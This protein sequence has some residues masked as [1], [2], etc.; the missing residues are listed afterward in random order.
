MNG[1]VHQYNYQLV[2]LSFVLAMVGSF[3]ALTIVTYLR[4]EHT[5]RTQLIMEIAGAFV[6]GGT[7]WSMHF[8]GMLAMQMRMVV[9]Y[10]LVTTLVSL[11]AAI[12]ASFLAFHTIAQRIISR[13]RH[14]FSALVMGAGIC[15]MHYIGM[16]AMQID[17]EV[18]HNP[19]TY[20]LSALI[21]VGASWA[22][23]WMA[24]R[25]LAGGL[26]HPKLWR[27]LAAGIMAFAICGMHYVGMMAAQVFPFA[28]C[29]F[30]ES[31]PPYT[32]IFAILVLQ[33]MT[34]ATALAVALAMREKIDVTQGE[35]FTLQRRLLL[36]GLF[37]AVILSI[38]IVLA[39]HY[40]AAEIKRLLP[41]SDG[42]RLAIQVHYSVV[43]TCFFLAYKFLVKIF[44]LRSMRH[45]YSELEQ[46][47]KTLAL[48]I[49]QKEKAEHELQRW[50]IEVETA[51]AAAM[52]AKE[53][54]ENANSAKSEFLANMS[55]EI[56]TPMN[57][58]LGMTQLLLTTPLNP[59]QRGWAEIVLRSGEHLL[60]II[61]DVLDFSKIEAGKMVLEPINFDLHETIQEI[62]NVVM[63]RTQAKGLELL[64]EF[65]PNVPRFLVGD[66][67]RL[68]QVVLNLVGNAIKFTETGHVLIRVAALPDVNQTVRLFLEIED[69]GCGIPADK[70]DYI[71][72]KFTQAEE[73]TTRK[74]GGTGLGLAIS[75]ELVEMMQGKIGVRS[76]VGKGTTF[77][78]DIVL[79]EGQAVGRVAAVAD[80]NLEFTRVLLVNDYLPG[81]QIAHDI[82]Q[83]EGVRCNIAPSAEAM[84]EALNE[85]EAGGDPYRFVILDDHL[86]R[87]RLLH[88]AAKI[89]GRQKAFPRTV[90]LLAPT[91]SSAQA[92]DTQDCLDG[93]LHKPCFAEYLLGML[94]LLQ[95]DSGAHISHQT[96]HKMLRGERVS[97]NEE[98]VQFPGKRALVV[99]DLKVN[100]LLMAKLLTDLGCTVDK[101][102]NGKEA[103]SLMQRLR[104][105]I[106]FM[107]C[108]MPEM[109][110]FEATRAIRNME[111]GKSYQTVIVALT[112]D[113]LTGDREKCLAAGMDDYINK[114]FKLEDIVNTI[115]KWH[116]APPAAV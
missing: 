32:L 101:A 30:G 86:G 116:K 21:A 69:T 112:A 11:F 85:A 110:G 5:R 55:H 23:L 16:A 14:L 15:C 76:G 4:G 93:V 79:P 94:R 54:A 81:A 26:S 77:H 39:S 115:K 89:K 72:E 42:E 43:L 63:L 80:G 84:L 45:W 8:I 60:D 73:S 96:V 52:D 51:R 3:V 47:R 13:K 78:F 106:V 113:A 98:K 1:V 59:E 53:A 36:G 38:W 102:A 104:Y 99:D 22:A 48:R 57:G 49:K 18:R 82:L 92:P 50:I 46:T 100:Q 12:A 9:T 90:A 19:I 114:P 111:A 27:L 62:C 34:G 103:V 75:R 67:G 88:Y 65:M 10:D 83:Q 41:N 28:D 70:L 105:E 58:V 56:R 44:V 37:Y 24:L 108:Q 71:F 91:A 6:L 64:V 40:F 17:A 95:K 2:C 35:S 66:S 87:E 74:F 97:L 107:D 7:I 20:A 29:R 109:D 61:N 31:P 33:A 68:K 25:L